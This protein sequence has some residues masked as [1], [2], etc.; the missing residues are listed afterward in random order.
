[1]TSKVRSMT[2]AWA[3]EVNAA[4]AAPAPKAWNFIIFS[5]ASKLVDFA[6]PRAKLTPGHNRV[7][8]GTRN[9]LARDASNQTLDRASVAPVARAGLQRALRRLD[10]LS[11]SHLTA[12][13][14]L[15]AWV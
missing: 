1:M 8:R 12:M 13:R 7:K 9:R 10:E 6:N 14:P 11:G 15:A 4:N 5:P 2:A 3:K